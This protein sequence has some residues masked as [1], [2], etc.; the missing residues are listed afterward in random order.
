MSLELHFD[1]AIPERSPFI[2]QPFGY[3]S[4]SVLITADPVYSH[5]NCLTDG[6]LFV[7]VKCWN[8]EEFMTGLMAKK[9]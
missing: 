9:Y 4:A 1:K 7:T 6:L 5:L 8:A 3:R 2:I